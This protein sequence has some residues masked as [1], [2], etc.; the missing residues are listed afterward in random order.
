MIDN[1][2]FVDLRNYVNRRIAYGRYRIGSTW[3][4]TLLSDIT[5][6]PSGTV[7]A[8][9]EIDPNQS[10]VTINRVELYNSDRQLWAHEDC[11]ITINVGQT[12][13]LYWFD[14]T[15]KEEDAN[16]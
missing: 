4:E 11:S 3:H 10:P 15:F 7:R 5:V 14:F 13:V 1:A 16:V 9:I 8:Q 2:G 6:L 12:G